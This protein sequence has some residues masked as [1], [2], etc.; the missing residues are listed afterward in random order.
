LTIAGELEKQLTVKH[1]DIPRHML[2]HPAENR[3]RGL[4]TLCRIW[5]S[6]VNA[7]TITATR[8]LDAGEIFLFA[9][10]SSR[11]GARL[12]DAISNLGKV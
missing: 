4:A 11:P 10:R 12:A 1:G 6:Q 5:A 9:I 3:R 8:L 2:D 7:P